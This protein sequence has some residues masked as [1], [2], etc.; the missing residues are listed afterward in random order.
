MNAPTQRPIDFAHYL[1]WTRLLRS[2]RIATDP[3]KL[4]LA[5]LGVALFWAGDRALHLLPFKP[6]GARGLEAPWEAVRPTALFD[7]GGTAVPYREPLDRFLELERRIL[8]PLRPLLEVVGLP[9]YAEKDWTDVAFAWTRL[10]WALAVWALF[11]GAIARIA[12]V[13]FA[14]DERPGLLDATGFAA[15]RFVSLFSAPLLP[16]LGVVILWAG[17]GLGGLVGRIP[18]V[19][20]WIA[21]VLWGLA[22]L[23]SL[24]TLLILIAT[25]AGWPLM[26]AAVAA[27]GSDAFDGFSRSF[28]YLYGRPWLFAWYAGLALLLGPLLVAAVDT[29][30]AGVFAAASRMVATGMGR[31]AVDTLHA[32]APGYVRAALPLSV[33]QEPVTGP[34][35]LAG[36]WLA[37]LATVAVGFA[38]SYFWTASTIVYFLLRR[39]DDATHFDD[40]WLDERDEEDHLLPLAGIAST[41]QPVTERSHLPTVGPPVAA[42]S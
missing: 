8:A 38:A 41:D 30:A 20:E 31:N 21:A 33:G 14:R 12:A 25:A 10:F 23:A 29:L 16:L 24:L 26:I 32:A 5:A 36:V 13:E 9:L 28:S 3:R 1:P 17:C 15:R 37:V 4:A 18:V 7:L 11:G 42:P 34:S 19:G 22:A 40:V 39:A 27:E 6:A 35:R 2:F